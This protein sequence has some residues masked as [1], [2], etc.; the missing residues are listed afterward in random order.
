MKSKRMRAWDAAWNDIE[1][2][3][4]TS[5][6]EP[7]AL[8]ERLQVVLQDLCHA[9]LPAQAIADIG[10]AIRLAWRIGMQA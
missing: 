10:V 1:A 7:S 3:A 2:V 5:E 9:P 6:Y 4:G 8:Q